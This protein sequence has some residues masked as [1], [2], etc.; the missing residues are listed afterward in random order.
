VLAA[1]RLRFVVEVVAELHDS[2]A[3]LL[4]GNAPRL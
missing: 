3:I 4:R 1:E 2:I